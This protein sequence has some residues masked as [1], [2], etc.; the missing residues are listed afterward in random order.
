MKFTEYIQTGIT[1]VLAVIL[2]YGWINYS[3]LKDDAAYWRGEALTNA[4]MYKLADSTAVMR[5][6]EITKL[7]SDNNILNGRIA[8]QGETIRS[9]TVIKGKLEKE[10]DWLKTHPD[11]VWVNGVQVGVRRFEENVY[12]FTIKG[13]FQTESPFEIKFERLGATVDLD[14]TLTEDKYKAWTAYVSSKDSSFVVT[15]VIPKVSPYEPGFMEKL[16]FGAGLYGGASRLG[17]M[18][19]VYYDKHALRLMFDTQG[20][21]LAYERT[22]KIN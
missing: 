3:A 9:L 20:A 15:E 19:S 7:E 13:Y 8:E 14:V 18:T 10:I 17:V 16:Y 6:Q 1:A 21:S 11:T 22:F 4:S 2:V 5:A 12:P